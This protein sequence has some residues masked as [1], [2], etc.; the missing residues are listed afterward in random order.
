MWDEQVARFKED[1]MHGVGEISKRGARRVVLVWIAF[2][3]ALWIVDLENQQEK[4][5]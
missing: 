4:S 1:I 5:S 3:M 2:R